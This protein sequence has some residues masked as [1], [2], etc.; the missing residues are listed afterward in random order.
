MCICSSILKAIFAPDPKKAPKQRK[1]RP[2]S[3]P[4]SRF[5]ILKS[6]HFSFLQ[7]PQVDIDPSENHIEDSESSGSEDPQEDSEEGP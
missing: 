2:I 4:V 5:S 1:G 7:V 3:G 6:S